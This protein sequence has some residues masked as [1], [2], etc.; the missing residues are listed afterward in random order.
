MNDSSNKVIVTAA[1]TGSGSQWQKNPNVPITPEEIADQGIAACEAGASVCHIHVRDPKT[2]APNPTVELYRDVV[3]RIRGNCDVIIQLTTGGGGPHGVSFEQ[4]MCALGL[5]PEFAS[6]NVATMTFGDSVFMNP[7]ADVQKIAGFMLSQGIKAEVECYDMGHIELANQLLRKGLLNDP[8]RISLVLGVVG[9]IPA[10]PE[11]LLH[12]M[13]SL[14]PHCR[15]NVVCIGRTQFPI[16]TIGL[17]LGTDVRVGMEDNVYLSKGELARSNAELVTKIVRI[18]KELGK[19]IATPS[20]ARMLLGIR[21][22]N[23]G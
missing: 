15:P 18:A 5:K 2:K 21:T 16:L 7:P 3:E 6:L 23:V 19:E 9:G 11:H 12:M 8:L 14:P 17:N 10:K 20:D 1:L 13:N 22:S 4:R